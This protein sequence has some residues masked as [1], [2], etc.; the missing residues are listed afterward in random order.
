MEKYPL[1]SVKKLQDL[2]SKKSNIVLLDA[3]IDK[4]TEKFDNANAEYIE[5]TVFFDIENKFSDKTS[6]LPHTM[7]SENTF[8]TNMQDLG[9]NNE[10]IIVIYDQWGVYSSP[11]AWWMLRYMG[12]EKTYVLNG[13]IQAWKAQNLSTVSSLREPEIKGN[14]KAKENK[15]WIE[16]KETLHQ[17]IGKSDIT[18]TDARGTGR[19]NGTAPEP[20]PGLRSGHIPYSSNLP[21][22]QVVDGPYLKNNEE[23]SVLLADHVDNKKQNIFSCG[24]GITASILALA[25]YS[26]GIENVSVYDGSWAEWGSD[27]NLPIEK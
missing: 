13:G 7:I 24:S 26:T 25:T 12:H 21:F 15:N 10:D 22:D 17:K 18:I 1:L 5:G 9:I 2:I 4:V 8:S 20:R 11:R 23:L 6:N 16:S 3:T 14:F 19:F 27:S